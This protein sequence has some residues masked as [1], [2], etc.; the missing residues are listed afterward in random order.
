MKIMK[1]ILAIFA[2][3]ALVVTTYCIPVFAEGS[4]YTVQLYSQVTD[5][6]A[7]VSKAR[8]YFGDGKKPTNVDKDTFKVHAKVTVNIG[9]N[10]GNTYAEADRTVVKV[11][12]G[13]GYVDIYFDL[14]EG[15]GTV[16]TWLSE[17]RNYPG[18]L[19]YTFTQEKT[20]EL[21]GDDG[22]PLPAIE[23][24][25]ATYTVVED[26]NGNAQLIDEEV[27]KFESVI[28]ENGINY[29]YYDADKGDS[30]IVWFHGNG[31]GDVLESQNNISQ[32][33]GNRGAVAYTTEESQNI[34][35]GVDVM[36]FQ[37]PSTWYYNYKDNL[38][39][40]AYNEIQDVIKQK[41]IDPE[42]VYVAGCSAGG[43]M[44]TTMIMAYPDLFKAAMI[45]CPAL[46]IAG[47]SGD[48]YG[49]KTPT[50][51][52]I[53]KLK[54]SKTAI[55]LVQGD[56]DTSV[57]PDVCA[58]RMWKILSEGQ[59]VKETRVEQFTTTFNSDYTTY[60]TVDGKYKFS[61]Y[62]TVETN[63]LT[64]KLGVTRLGGKLQFGEDYDL[65]GE[66]ESLTYSDHWVWI[67][68][69]RN[70]PSDASGTHIWQWAT[71]YTVQA[72]EAPVEKPTETPNNQTATPNK[73]TT[74]VKTGDD[75]AI[76][77]MASIM[78]LSAGA[79]V[80]IKKYAR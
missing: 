4:E 15:Q 29:Q 31:E 52:D 5:A 47:L 65:D 60:E 32:L 53:A 56:T 78:M 14:D 68:T 36:A 43:Y 11:V 44:S 57:N 72:A 46:D 69:L 61:M 16:L 40:K 48:G 42:K 34:F 75:S 3:I 25:K 67:Y 45:N 80:T 54:E 70:N 13:S 20:I 6:G 22:S 27:D 66:L 7:K 33:L 74:S 30:L 55:W 23:A 39:E 49:G 8:I 10:K 35:G 63:E 1:K 26:K 17:A 38:L 51:E 41:G 24:Q 62:D 77:A 59:E 58:K 19:D 9:V 12:P 50:D 37:A 2:A 79:Y 28:V 71:N 18:I 73:T 21:T 76:A 64:D